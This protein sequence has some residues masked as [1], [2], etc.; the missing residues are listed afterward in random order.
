MVPCSGDVDSV[1]P[2]TS[3]RYFINMLDL[4]VKT[5]WRAWYI[6]DE[7]VDIHCYIYATEQNLISNECASVEIL[8]WPMLNRLEGM[9][10]TTKD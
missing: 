1:C 9:W 5:P 4:T 7:V 2:V 6:N 8:K 3:T 10:L